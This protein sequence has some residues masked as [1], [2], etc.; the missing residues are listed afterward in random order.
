[1]VWLVSPKAGLTVI[2]TSIRFHK[3]QIDLRL[4]GEGDTTSTV[5][6]YE[7]RIHNM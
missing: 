4:Q 6:C 7:E 1:M 5:G 3:H 2:H